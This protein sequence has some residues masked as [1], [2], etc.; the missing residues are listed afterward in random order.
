MGQLSPYL[1][2]DKN[3]REAMNFYKDCLGGELFLQAVKESP[4]MAAQ[5]PAEMGEHIL[6]SSL[7]S[8]NIT[9]MASDLTRERKVEGNSVHLC[10]NCDSEEELID[11]FSRLSSGGNIT[12]PLADMPW[13]GKYAGLT[14]KYGKH[15]LFNFQND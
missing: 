11:F 9:I 4:L 10:I 2:F 15:W 6:H 13:G 1:T 7:S 8:G 14:D 5:M 12:E 3:C